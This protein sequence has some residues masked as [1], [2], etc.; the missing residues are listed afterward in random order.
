M[1]YKLAL[2]GRIFEEDYKK[3]IPLEKFVKIA[4]DIGYQGIE[5]RSTQVSLETPYKDVKKYAGIIKDYGLEVVCMEVRGYP[6]LENENLFINC[7]ELAR[8][9]NCK[10]IKIGGES[11][12]TRRY[13][14]ISQK[15]GIKIGLNN[16]I[17]TENNPN[18]TETIERTVSY[19]NSINHPNFGILYDACHLFISGSEYGEEAINKIK[20]KIF[21]VLVQYIVEVSEEN[22]EIKFHNRYFRNGIIGG[23]GSAVAEVISEEYP[24]PLNRIGINDTFGESGS[25]EDILKKYGLT[26]Q[27]IVKKSKLLLKRR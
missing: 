19:L 15:Y 26:V 12:K 6:L 23:L 20:D 18:Y 25:N 22:S 11:D 27:D 1:E 2:S 4:S 7:L 24:V 14:E 17:G 5:L 13:A 9:F 21:Y 16:H 3:N 8:E 10:I